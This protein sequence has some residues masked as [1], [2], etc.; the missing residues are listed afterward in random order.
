MIQIMNECTKDNSKLGKRIRAD[1][2]SVVIVFPLIVHVLL[3]LIR[4]GN[5]LQKLDRGHDDMRGMFKVVKGIAI[6]V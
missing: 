1:S 6:S 2:K 3:L 4:S 5:S